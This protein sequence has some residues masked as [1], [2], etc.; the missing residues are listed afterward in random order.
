MWNLKKQTARAVDRAI[1]RRHR[2]FATS[3]RVA[4]AGTLS[5]S[6]GSDQDFAAASAGTTADRDGH[7]PTAA[8]EGLAGTNVE[9]PAVTHVSQPGTDKQMPTVPRRRDASADDNGACD[10]AGA[11]T[12]RRNED[13]PAASC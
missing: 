4:V 11:C 8:I 6:P 13:A 12:R 10:T 7:I 9:I 3:S 5:A 1:T 2:D